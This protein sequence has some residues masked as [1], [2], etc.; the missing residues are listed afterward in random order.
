MGDVAYVKVF[1]PPFIGA[2]GGGSGAIAVYTKK[3]DEKSVEGE[4]LLYKN[5]VGYTPVAEFYSPHYGPFD[6]TNEVDDIRTTLYWN[7]ML[8]TNEENHYII[9]TFYNNDVSNSFRVIMEGMS[10]DG[11]LTRFEKVVK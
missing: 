2:F 1:M 6:T 10:K 8:I 9:L 11:R 5:V 7:P 3:G 4:A